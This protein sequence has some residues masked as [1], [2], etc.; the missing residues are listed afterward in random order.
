V[1]FF[2]YIFLNFFIPPEIRLIDQCVFISN[3]PIKIIHMT[4]KIKIR[5]AKYIM[6]YFSFSKG[7]NFN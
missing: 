6:F 3:F 2:N 4:G 5:G 1:Y 7:K